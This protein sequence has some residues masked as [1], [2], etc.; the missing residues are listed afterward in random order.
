MRSRTLT[1]KW[2]VYLY[3]KSNIN[4]LKQ[5]CSKTI[6]A[7]PNYAKRLSPELGY[8]VGVLLGDGYVSKY[9]LSLHVKDLDFAEF[10]AFQVKHWCN[11]FPPIY[12]YKSYYEVK[13]GFVEACR[14]LKKLI[15]DL[16]WID[17]SDME[18]K[19]MVLKGLWD[20]EGSVNESCIDFINTNDKVALL[21]QKLCQEFGIKITFHKYKKFYFVRI[22]M[23]EDKMKFFNEIGV[24]I[25]RKREKLIKMIS[26][27]SV[28][29]RWSE[30]E[31][32]YVLNNYK[33]YTDK[34]LAD[35][36]NRSHCS[37]V[38]FR[39]RNYLKKRRMK[40]WDLSTLIAK[41]KHTG[42]ILEKVEVARSCSSSA[43]A[44]K[45]LSIC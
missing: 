44:R 9:Y 37:I 29:K 33:N 43:R 14:F 6:R 26:K 38:K 31:K 25:A 41:G 3:S 4:K 2:K 21:Y 15:S 28:Y 17:K 18:V 27:T 13:I 12:H 19:R 22:F 30:N 5:I 42:C 24:T 16:S 36:L 7:L 35:A 34:E 20:S 45:A 32:I 40:T 1:H 39:E 11:V 23:K 8:I 10:F